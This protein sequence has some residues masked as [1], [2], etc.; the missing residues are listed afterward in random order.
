MPKFCTKNER[1][2]HW[3]NW[4]IFLNVILHGKVGICK[5]VTK[6]HVWEGC[7][8]SHKVSQMIE[9]SLNS[10]SKNNFLILIDL[11]QNQ[12]SN[13]YFHHW[14]YLFGN[15]FSPSWT[16]SKFTFLPI[17]TQH[18]RSSGYLWPR[19]WNGTC[20]NLWKVTESCDQK[21]IQR[22]YKHLS[23]HFR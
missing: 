14:K 12:I 18:T 7:I 6:C 2:K 19:I 20:F 16:P 17:S 1:I 22:R 5:S 9:M 21:W 15:R 3:W 10:N 8:K 11:W 23:Y 13:H 4:Q